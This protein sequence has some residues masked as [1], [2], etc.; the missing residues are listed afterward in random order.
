MPGSFEWTALSSN[1]NPIY[2]V[3]LKLCRGFLDFGFD[4]VI[5]PR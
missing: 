3:L 2:G 1:E 4:L 5:L